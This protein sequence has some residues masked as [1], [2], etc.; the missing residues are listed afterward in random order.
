MEQ[1]LTNSVLS[2]FLIPTVSHFRRLNP[3]F[4]VSNN[5][6]ENLFLLTYSTVPVYFLLVYFICLV[7]GEKRANYAVTLMFYILHC[8][9]LSSLFKSNL[10]SLNL[11]L[12]Y[13]F[14][15][16]SPPTYILSS[17]SDGLISTPTKF[18]ILNNSPVHNLKEIKSLQT[19]PPPLVWSQ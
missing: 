13:L 18:N 5:F 11:D 17:F 10:K 7:N 15:E 6:H 19:P 1:F 8:Y 12:E 14:D 4:L 16:T 3:G 2:V 9:Y